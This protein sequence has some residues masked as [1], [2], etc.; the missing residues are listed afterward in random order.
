[1]MVKKGPIEG[2]LQEK[3]ILTEQGKNILLSLL[4]TGL[5]FLLLSAKYDFYYDLND[6]MAIRDILAG[7]HTGDPSAYS[8][9]MLFPLSWIL[10]MCYRIMPQIPWFGAFLSFCQ[11]IFVFLTGFKLI[12]PVK[13]LWLRVSLW[14][15]YLLGLSVVLLSQFIFVQ[16]TVV[17]GMLMAAAV[18]WSGMDGLP[19][20]NRAKGKSEI[21]IP[22]ILVGVAF[23]IRTEMCLMLLPFFFLILFCNWLKSGNPFSMEKIKCAYLPLAGALLLML[24]GYSVHAVAYSNAEWKQFMHFFDARTTLYDFIGIPDYE[25]NQTFYETNH[26]TKEEYTLL[27]NYNFSLDDALNEDSFGKIIAYRQSQAGTE[28]SQPIYRYGS[29]YT[30]EN[31]KNA[32]WSY[33]QRLFGEQE[34]AWYYVIAALYVCLFMMATLQKKS[35]LYGE[36]FLLFA[37]R[38]VIWLYLLVRNRLPERI[39]IPLYLIEAV[40][41]LIWLM[42]QLCALSD[43]EEKRKKLQLW[44]GIGVALILAMIL[45]VNLRPAVMQVSDQYAHREQVNTRWNA[46]REY[47][48]S[49][50]QNYYLLDVYSTTAYSEK[51]Y[52]N[53]DNSF[54]NFDL[55]GGWLA[56]SPLTA[57]KLLRYDIMSLEQSLAESDKIYFIAATDR[58]MTWLQDY[59]ERKEYRVKIEKCDTIAD[60]DG[61]EIFF[62]YRL[63]KAW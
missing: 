54:R 12:E 16:Y 53:V 22:V 42:E 37:G 24:F 10:G 39:L 23:Q 55:C 1:M 45:T 40:I 34:D 59:Y 32:L 14:L 25:E 13:K 15:G 61:M 38:S 3:I 44:W 56:K 31:L 41:L 63:E 62:V 48:M 51:I 8:I 18:F 19:A 57:Q 35:V 28:C 52:K 6:D 27:K 29:L 4:F 9:Q 17:C 20:G 33:R 7:I 50:P 11:M 5:F 36:I 46:L 2:K 60:S 26:L 58:D 47:C 49:Y 21:L 43:K 30:T